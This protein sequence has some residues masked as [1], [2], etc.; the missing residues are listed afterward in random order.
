MT[1]PLAVIVRH[2]PAEVVRLVIAREVV[3]AFVARS[4]VA[5]SAVEVALVATSDVEKRLVDVELVMIAEVAP[6]E[7]DVA[8]VNERFVPLIAV[9]E[10]KLMNDGA[11]PETLSIP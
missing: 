7:V 4:D 10:A 5:K 6:S 11:A 9:V 2:W 1:L 3:V 8:L